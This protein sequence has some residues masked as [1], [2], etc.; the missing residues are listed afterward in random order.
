MSPLL[1]TLL[2]TS[3][4]VDVVAALLSFE[5]ELSSMES[6]SLEHAVIAAMTSIEIIQKNLLFIIPLFIVYTPNT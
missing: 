5:D 4:A 2:S 3:S 6:S 1:V